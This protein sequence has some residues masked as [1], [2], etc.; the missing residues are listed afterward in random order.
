MWHQWLNFNFANLQEYFCA[1]RKLFFFSPSYCLPPFWIVSQSQ[2]IRMLYPKRK[3]H[4][5]RRLCSWVLSKM[6]EDASQGEELLKKY[7]FVFFAHKKYSRSFAKLSHWC[8]MDC[9]TYVLTMFLDL[10]TLMLHCCRW[11]GQRALRFHEKISSFVFQRW[12]EVFGT[13]WR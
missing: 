3:Q 6:V 4:W 10:G 1:R 12:T 7:I 11:E 2:C 5:L 9:F 13:A 8:H